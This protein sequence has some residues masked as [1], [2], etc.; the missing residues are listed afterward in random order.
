M[1]ASHL[2]AQLLPLVGYVVAVPDPEAVASK[3]I[4]KLQKD[5]Q[6]YVQDTIKHR[7]TGCT[8][9]KILERKEW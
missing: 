4:D 5:Y 3:R 8:K 2:L 7:T 1:K 6:K 9:N